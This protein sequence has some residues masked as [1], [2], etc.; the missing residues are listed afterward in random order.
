MLVKEKENA[1]ASGFSTLRDEIPEAC[2]NPESL[3]VSCRQMVTKIRFCPW[4]NANSRRKR[5]LPQKH[6]W[7]GS[8]FIRQVT[9]A[10][11]NLKLPVMGTPSVGVKWCRRVVGWC[12]G[13]QPLTVARQSADILLSP[14]NLIRSRLHCRS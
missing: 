9:P 12:S 11:A 7:F 6:L 13:R 8:C 5:N 1:L 10:E 3:Q 4:L 14:L 2:L